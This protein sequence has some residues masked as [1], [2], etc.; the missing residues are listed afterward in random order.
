MTRVRRKASNHIYAPPQDSHVAAA[1]R[2][3]GLIVALRRQR[4]SV[5]A[6]A[7]SAHSRVQE[8]EAALAASEGA[9][10]SLRQQALG[11]QKRAGQAEQAAAEAKG[12]LQVGVVEYSFRILFDSTGPGAA[13]GGGVLHT[14]TVTHTCTH[15]LMY[16]C[17]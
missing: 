14:H 17:I 12:Q 8:L 4:E 2:Y 3:E 1:E 6:L 15:T 9:A 10:A 11:A 7:A 5:E 16:I 13:A